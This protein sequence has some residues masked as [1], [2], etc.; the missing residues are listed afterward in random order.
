MALTFGFWSAILVYDNQKTIT[1]RMS[2]TIIS[3]AW[4]PPWL[5]LMT[6]VS[7][8]CLL[9]K[10]AIGQKSPNGPKKKSGYSAEPASK[11]I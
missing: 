2:V 11:G 7:V 10:L 9:N 3:F 1:L 8:L 6:A 4:Q 5:V